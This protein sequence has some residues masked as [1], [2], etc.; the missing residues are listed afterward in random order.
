MDNPS[1][2]GLIPLIL[3]IIFCFLPFGQI[4]AVLVGIVSAAI[5]GGHGLMEVAGAIRA[6]LGSFLGYIGLIILLGGG[7]GMVLKR[8]GVVHYMVNAVTGKL[9]VD[10]QNKAFFV[11]ML[12]SVVIVSLLGT[13]AGGNAIIAPILIPIAASMG[14]V[15]NAMAV[16]LH[17][18]GATG[19]FLG[20]FTP[21]VVALTEF[22]GVNYVQFLLNAGLPVSIIMWIVTFFWAGH[23]QKKYAG[24]NS[25]AE[26]VESE[27]DKAM[28]ANPKAGRASLVFFISMVTL[29]AYGIVKEGGSTFVLAI[30][31]ITAALTGIAGGLK[32]SDIIGAI[33]D[34]AKNLIWLF[35]FFVLLDPFINFISDAGA[36]QA[37]AVI[38][39]P[40]VEGGSKVAFVAF[41]TLVG[42]F[43]VPGAAVAQAE[44]LN[45]MFRALA[46]TQ[47]IPMTVWAIVLLI[48]SQM[49]SFAF[50][51][52]DMQGQMG[53]ARSDDLISVLQNGWL[54]VFFT[55]I[56]AVVRAMML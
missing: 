56:Y 29:V 24:K 41:T 40:Y 26:A 9:K 35:F 19:L 55:T 1:L 15:P 33:C 2:I 5:I 14:V 23:V 37:L 16:L 17:G 52:G 10:S 47:G 38:L 36:F 21:P 46:E 6:G 39:K 3:Y 27:A 44:I 11:V 48:G 12:T 18:A 28:A 50:P 34:G 51:E 13:M 54:I 32:A 53:L 25:Y 42:I 22:T 49:T 43:G 4:F 30:M 20:P 8:T 31:L 7:L 45:K